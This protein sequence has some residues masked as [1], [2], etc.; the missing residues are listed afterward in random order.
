MQ[1]AEHQCRECQGKSP[2]GSAE[3]L[4]RPAGCC[5]RAELRRQVIVATLV[6]FHGS[7][8]WLLFFDQSLLHKN[9]PTME[10]SASPRRPTRLQAPRQAEVEERAAKRGR[11]MPSMP[12]PLRVVFDDLS[13]LT[14][15]S[16]RLQVSLLSVGTPSNECCRNRP[17]F[18]A[19]ISSDLILQLDSLH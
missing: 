10:P 16:F 12:V 19:I 9:P 4:L 15:A 1:S 13:P 8:F 3:L 17:M 2:A 18:M 11:L 14:M 7:C 6:C 5:C